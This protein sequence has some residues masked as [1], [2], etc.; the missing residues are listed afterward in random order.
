MLGA[1]KGE[2]PLSPD[3]AHF[4]AT[5]GCTGCFLFCHRQALKQHFFYAPLK[6]CLVFCNLCGVNQNASVCLFFPPRPQSA[7]SPFDLL[8]IWLSPCTRLFILHFNIWWGHLWS[9]ECGSQVTLVY[10]NVFLSVI[11]L[12]FCSRFWFFSCTVSYC[13]F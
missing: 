5:C 3:A 4:Q 8:F 10:K 6:R 7:I 9:V 12:F 1:V 11:P 13:A 2:N